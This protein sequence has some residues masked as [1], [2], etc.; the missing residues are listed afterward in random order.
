MV[1]AEKRYEYQSD[2]WR[3]SFETVPAE[4]TPVREET[5]PLITLWDKIK[6]I[7]LILTAGFLCVCLII[8][9]AYSAN[10]KYEINT[11][12]KENAALSGEIENLNVQIKNATNIRS[13]EKKAA[14]GLGM[15][16]PASEQ[17]VFLSHHEKPKGDFAMLLMEHAYNN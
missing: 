1:T 12:I 10:V 15:I 13:I 16:Y 9:A 14:E 2:Y 11:I 5:K 17:F 3:N 8:S 4:E 7:S 6:M